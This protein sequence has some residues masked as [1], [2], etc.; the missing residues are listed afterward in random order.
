[1]NES[2]RGKWQ[3]SKA[4][5]K[6]FAQ[7]MGEI[8]KYCREHNINQS[9]TG[10]SYYFVINGQEYRVSNHSVEASYVNSGGKYHDEG[11][12]EDIIYIHAG[13]T[14]IIDIHQNL[15]KGKKLDGKGNVISENLEEQV[16]TE[17]NPKLW[18][19]DKL[20]PEVEE[21]L[22]EIADNFVGYLEEDEIEL[23]IKDIIIIG[24]NANYNY[25]PES[26][27]D[28]HIIADMS[29]IEQD[30]EKRLLC[31]LY[32]AYRSLF[33]NKYDITIKGQEVE[34][35]V[36]SDETNTMSNGVYSLFTGWL[37][38]P[39]SVENDSSDKQDSAF[40]KELNIWI[41]KYNEV[42]R[43]VSLFLPKSLETDFDDFTKDD[44]K[45]IESRRMMYENLTTSESQKLQEIDDFIKALYQLRKDSL[46]TDGEYGVGNEVFKHLRRHGY[47]KR[48]RDAKTALKEKELSLE[49]LSEMKE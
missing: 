21:K 11:R 36:E 44:A 8:D 2:Y 45:L 3:P 41:D 1:M 22:I 37:K 46:E 13:K 18:Q 38:V 7:K 47:I 16:A 25:T 40:D 39:E 30:E 42:M 49:N 27:I 20:I 43:G 6:E 9:S 17:L 10:D 48:L 34:V 19:D 28:L 26:D 29:D 35:Y 4:A 31:I 23:R 33:N 5:K 32:N 12:N 14:R 24:S 15:L